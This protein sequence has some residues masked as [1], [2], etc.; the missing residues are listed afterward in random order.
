[1]ALP[2]MKGPA[3][4]ARRLYAAWGAALDP[5]REPP[6]RLTVF[7]LLFAWANLLHQLSF[8]DWIRDLQPLGWIVFLA[9]AALC[10]TPSSL[11]LFVALLGARIAYTAA[12]SP[13]IRGHL[14]FEGLLALG[15]ALAMA[16]H[17]ARRGGCRGLD[18]AAREEL[19]ESFAP[20][21]RWSCLVIYGAVTLS[22]L[23][24]QF[25]DPQTSAAVQFVYW[26]AEMHPWI[27]TGPWVRDVAI[28]GTLAVEGG[29]PVLLCVRRT[30]WIALVVALAFHTILGLTPLRIASFTLTMFL[31]LFPWTP[32]EAPRVWFERF[33]AMV[34][35]SRVR[36]R[37]F[38]ACLGAAMVAT[39]CAY[40][41]VSAG[42]N[43]GR[44]PLFFGLGLWWWQT[45]IVAA[46]LWSIR[47]LRGEATSA[48]LRLRSFTLWAYLAFLAFNC[49]C[50]YLGLK[51]R[52]AL[53]MHCNLRTEKGHWNHLFLPERMRVF[54]YQD[55]LV[56]VL[57]SNLAD[58]DYLARK[59]MPL[60]DFEFRR[61][62]RLATADF[63]VVYQDPRGVTRRF[64]KSG[65][66]GSDPEVM[67]S[68]P[69][70]ERFLCFN[71]VGATHDYI[72]ELVPRVGPPRNVVPHYDVPAHRR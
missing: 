18:R 60:P 22:K 45:L 47:S 32:K 48:L 34:R 43:V 52:S 15:V 27:P 59:R 5:G 9:S 36:P 25:I 37:A 53:A 55:E 51:T 20:F 14:F 29:V 61:W 12:W 16:I 2:G 68:S 1:M 3:D 7:A 31:V 41:L 46:A 63:Y 44:Y 71:P 70:L 56:T 58:L 39:G 50:P 42:R 19:F 67:G 57:E 38:V 6:S 11:P 24:H 23:N 69:L 62:C 49:L 13:M 28:W 4:H 35:A 10:V 40:A 64:E 21:L 17:C 26:T 8:K 66:R 65:G 54:G 30:R 33:H 72:P